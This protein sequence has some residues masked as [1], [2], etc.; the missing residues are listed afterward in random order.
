MLFVLGIIWESS[1]FEHNY[2]YV[3]VK[4]KTTHLAELDAVTFY[5][6]NAVLWASEGFYCLGM[7]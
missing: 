7:I 3:I 2:T 4:F 5:F 6:L 1:F